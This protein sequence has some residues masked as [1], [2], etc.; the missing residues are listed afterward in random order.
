MT[1]KLDFAKRIAEQAG[2]LAQK[3]RADNR[4]NGDDFIQQKGTQDFV[5]VADK[6]VETLIRDA[7]Q[8]TY[9]HDGILGEEDGLQMADNSQ[10]SGYWVVDP[11]DGTTNFMRGLADWGVCIA[12][13][14]G[15]K[16]VLGVI[17]VPDENNM[18]Y[19]EQGQ[20]AYVNDTPLRVTNETNPKKSLIMTGYSNRQPEGDYTTFLDILLDSGFE[21][22]RCGAA[23]IGAVRVANGNM[24]MYYESDINAWDIMAGIVIVTESGGYAR[25]IAVS[26]FM[27]K[28]S[29]IV[30]SNGKI[31]TAPF[32]KLCF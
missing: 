20:G 1:E 32:E 25:H 26:E 5:T 18:Y 9:P 27:S 23:C 28:R 11:I 19:A 21:Y 14:E 31:D 13:V 8:T 4:D 16:I 10:D 7:I 17:Y 24:E 2:R 29:P 3:I 22:R 30:L 6:Q 15:D 12:Y